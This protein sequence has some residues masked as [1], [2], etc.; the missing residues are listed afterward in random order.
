MTENPSLFYF[1]DGKGRAE[2]IRLIFVYG[3]IPFSDQR[4]SFSEYLFFSY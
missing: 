4:I 2:L 1:N 3:Q